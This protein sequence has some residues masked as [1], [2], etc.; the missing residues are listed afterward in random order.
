MKRRSFFAT[1]V[2]ALLSPLAGKPKAAPL[3]DQLRNTTGVT[4]AGIDVGKFPYVGG[5][6]YRWPL[7]PGE[8][9]F[10]RPGIEIKPLED[11][12]CDLE[13]HLD[14]HSQVTHEVPW[15][16]GATFR[17]T[18]PHDEPITVRL[19]FQHLDADTPIP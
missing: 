13:M 12:A 11:A 3:Q 8:I 4:L 19:A 9:I 10:F 6:G 5:F 1:C 2:A 15:A 7:Q 16:P 18:N 14:P 17:I